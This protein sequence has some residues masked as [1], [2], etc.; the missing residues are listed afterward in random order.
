MAS[1]GFLLLV[2]LRPRRERC[3][4]WCSL[5]SLR[6]LSLSLLPSSLLS[7]LLS[8]LSLLCV[9]VRVCGRLLKGPGNSQTWVMPVALV[10]TDSCPACGPGSRHQSCPDGSLMAAMRRNTCVCVLGEISVCVCVCVREKST[11]HRAL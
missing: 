7:L 8:L 10:C 2:V 4:C 11:R 3:R 6:V 1:T 9:L 5:L